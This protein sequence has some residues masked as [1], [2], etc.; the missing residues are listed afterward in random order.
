MAVL[1]FAKSERSF[2]GAGRRP[3][4]ERDPRQTDRPMTSSRTQE[5]QK[6]GIDSLV[7]AGFSSFFSHPAFIEL[8]LSG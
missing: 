7:A 8:I 5:L 6:N 1:W 3:D 2:T 4:D